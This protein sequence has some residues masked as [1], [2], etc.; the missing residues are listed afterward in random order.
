MN[1]FTAFIDGIATF[2]RRNPLT[3][4]FIVLLAVLA[5]ALLKGIA[6]FVLYF[7][8]GILVLFFLLSILFRV[9]I[10]RMR[11]QME[12]QFGRQNAAGTWSERQ[13]RGRA[14]RR[15]GEVR[16]YKTSDAP[17]KRVSKDVGDYVDFEET[18]QKPDD[19]PQN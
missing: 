12:E 11:K 1:Y 6:M 16:I 8:L 7:V 14:N 10:Y 9:R 18:E 15:E 17:R 4:L 3:V 19:G 2:I 13:T 5:P